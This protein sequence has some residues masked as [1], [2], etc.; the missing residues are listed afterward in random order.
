MS[1]NK[2]GLW[3]RLLSAALAFLMLFELSDS[4][5][6]YVVE[7]MV[8]APTSITFTDADGNTQN[9]DE[10][11]VEAF[12]YGAFAFETSGLAVKEGESG[13][14]KV[15]RL[16][17]TTGRA[18]AYLAYEPVAVQNEA[19]EAIYDY[20]LSADDVTIEV[21][22]PLPRAEYDPVGM[23]P[24]PEV[25]DATVAAVADEEGYILQLSVAADAYQWQIL[26]NDMWDDV[27]D[28]TEAEVPID[29]EY[30][31]GGVYDYRCVYTLDG[32]EY[33]SVSLAG[34][35]Y[36]KPVEEEVPQAPADLDLTAKPTYSALDLAGEEDPYSGWMFELVFAE[37]EWVKEIHVDAL[38]DDLSEAQ[39]AAAFTIWECEGGEVLESANTLLLRV[40]DINE[41]EPSTL[42]FTVSNITV[43]K[44]DGTAEVMIERVGGSQ[45]PVTVEYATADGT[46]VAG[47]DYASAS[48]TL[49]FYA[50]MTSLPVTVELIDD[51]MATDEAVWF[52]IQLS[53]LL[54]DDNCQMTQDV[55]RVEL[56]NSGTGDG[57]NLATQLYDPEA[58][59]VSGSVVESDSAA[60]AS[61]AAVTGTQS[62][63]EEA[64][65]V[66]STLVDPGSDGD[67]SLQSYSPSQKCISFNN[68]TNAWGTTADAAK[69][70]Y[71]QITKN[72][73][74]AS[75]N[76]AGTTVDGV[77]KDYNGAES[78]KIETGVALTSKTDT[79]AKL[80]DS[81]WAAL[82]GTSDIAG[83]MFSGFST[84]ITTRM[85]HDTS[86]LDG[87]SY[88]Y[89]YT[90]PRFNVTQGTTTLVNNPTYI[91]RYGSG[92][93][94]KKWTIRASDSNNFSNPFSGS[95]SKSF[96]FTGAVQ[97]LMNMPY[98]S[99]SDHEHDELNDKSMVWVRELKLTRR[100]FASNAFYTEV[101]TPNDS[102]TAPDKC[103]VLDEESYEVFEPAVEIVSGAGG[104]I[105]ATNQLFV[106]STLKISPARSDLPSG[107]YISDLVIYQSTD[108]GNTWKVFNKFG[109][110][111]Y[112]SASKTYTIKLVGTA[113]NPLNQNDLNAWYKV[114]VCYSRTSTVSVDFSPSVPRL[115]DGK[116]INTGKYGDVF[117]K[118]G[119][120]S[121][122]DF[123]S[124]TGVTGTVTYGYNVF[125]RATGDFKTE[126][127]TTTLQKPTSTTGSGV[128]ID[129]TNQTMKWSFNATNIQW[130]E[131]N[132]SPKDLVLINGGAYPG[133]SRIYL[134]E[135]DFSGGLSVLY[136]H[137][138]FQSAQSAMT[139]AISWMALYWDGNGN[140]KIDG[141][142]N[143][144]ISSF[145]L[146]ESSGDEFCGYIEAGSINEKQ[147]APK[148][149]DKGEYCQYF[150]KVCYTM[151][152]RSLVMPAGASEDERAQ[153]LPAFTTALN[154]DSTAYS[155]LTEELKSYRYIVSGLTKQSENAAETRSSDNHLK[156][157]AEAN[158]RSTLDIPLG[159]DISPA[160]LNSSNTAYVW[161]PVF[162]GNILYPFA[163]PEPITIENS[164]AGPTEVTSDYTMARDEEGI[165]TGYAYTQTGLDRMNG[166][167]SSFT[168]TT[169]FGL[170]TQEQSHTTEEIVDNVTGMKLGGG[171]SG[172]DDDTLYVQDA[173]DYAVR[174]DSVTLSG[175]S[176]TPDGEYLKEMKDNSEAPELDLDMDDA[177]T[178]WPEFNMD[179]GMN[180]GSMELSVLGG[181]T[182]LLDE[183]KIGFA[184]GV[185]FVEGG[186]DYKGF[187]DSN[188]DQWGAFMDFI[189][190]S[191]HG[192]EGYKKANDE[193]KRTHPSPAPSAATG[194]PS[195]SS[196]PSSS[197]PP[198]AASQN[199]VDKSKF[200]SKSYSIS[201]SS[202]VAFLFQYN[203]LD[204][205][206]YFEAMTVS[207]TGGFT[208]RFQGRFTACPILYLYFQF[209][210]SVEV[211]TGL[212]VIR[213]SVEV[214]TPKLNAKTAATADQRV[215][216][217]YM[218]RP[219][220]TGPIIT[221]AQYNS[222][223]ASQK[224]NYSPYD[225]S[226]YYY[227]SA[228]YAT[229]A[230]TSAES[231][232]KAAKDAYLETKE[233][234]LTPDQYNILTDTEKASYKAAP[235]TGGTVNYFYNAKNY[236]SYTD[237]V[238]AYN[239]ATSYSF[240]TSYKAF[241][242]RFSGKLSVEVQTQ[243]NGEWKADDSFYSGL[244]SSDGTGDTQVVL[245]KQDGMKLDKTVRVV[246]RP[247]EYE[248][249][250]VTMDKTTVTYVAEIQDIRNDVYWK[251]VSITP[252]IAVEVGAGVGIELL[253]LE[254]YGRLSAEATFLLGAYNTDY[255][256]YD[257]ITSNDN[258][259][260]PAK[261]D[262]FSAAVCAGLRLVLIFFNFEMD[263]VG[264]RVNYDGEKW[265]HGA[266]FLND[267][268]QS[269]SEDGYL[270][271]T[272]R[273]PQGTEQTFY[274]PEDNLESELGTLA[275]DPSDPSVPFQL[276]GYGSSVDAANLTGNMLL[277]SDYKVISAGDRD[278]IVY[279]ISRSG[280]VAGEDVS[281]LVMSELRQVSDGMGVSKYGLANPNSADTSGNLYLVL[282]NDNT[283]DLDFDVWVEESTSGT[284]TT[285][286]VHT[287][288]VSYDT[289]TTELTEP[290]KPAGDAYGGMTADN[291]KTV[292]APTEP[293]ESSYYTTKTITKDEYDK[294]TDDQKKLCEADGTNYKQ[295]TLASGY[296]TIQAAKDAYTAAQNTYNTAKA[297]YEAWYNYY[298]S[299]DSYN[300]FVQN[301]LKNAAQ[302]TVLKAAEWKY[303]STP[304]ADGSEGATI[305]ND[306]AFS[307]ATKL[308][309]DGNGST[310]T[311]GYVF[312]PASNGDGSAVFFG[313]TL[314]TDPKAY[315]QYVQ[316]LKNSG[317]DQEDYADYLKQTK[318]ST[319][320]VLGTQSNLNLAYQKSD[321]SWAVSSMALNAGQTL[322]NIEFT[323]WNGAYYLAYT[324]Q[325]DTYEGSGS[326]AEHVTA[327]RLFL[328]KV[329]VDPAATDPAKAVTWGDPYLLRTTRDYDLDKGTD[330]IYNSAGTLITAYDSPYFA[331]L[332]FLTAKIDPDM[333]TGTEET[334]STQ[335]VSEHTFLLFEMN[336]A[337]YLILDDSL[338]SITSS[339]KGTIYPFFTGQMFENEDGT[340]SQDASGKQEVTIGSDATGNLFAV[341]VG[342]VPN[343]TN[344][345]LYLSAYDANTNTW[346]DGVMLAMRNMDTYEAS[347]RNGWGDRTTQAAYL[348]F[349]GTNGLT[350]D[351]VKNLYPDYADDILTNL[352]AYPDDLGDKSNLTLSNV[353]AVQGVNGDLLV[354]TQGS[355]S[356]LGVTS[357]TYDGKT[358]YVVVPTYDNGS[359]DTE[360]GMYAISYSKGSQAL[361]EGTISFGQADF[362]MNSELY[363]ALSAVNTGDA[364]FRGSKNQ[365]ITATLSVAGQE[366]AAWTIAENIRSGQTLML[367]G[368]CLPL[369]S[370][371][372][373]GDQFVLT[374]KEDATYAGTAAQAEVTLFTVAE[375][376]DLGVEDLT[377]SVANVSAD[378]TTTTL[379][380]DFVAANRGSAQ[381]EDV[382]AQFTYAD[383]KDSNDETT[384]AVL[385]LTNSNL[386]IDQAQQLETLDASSNTDLANG[387]LKIYNATDGNND[388]EAGY[389]RRVHGTI[390]VPS[391]VFAMGEAGYLEL[392][393]ELFSK[394]DTITGSNVGVLTAIHD[395]YC[396]S[397][398][399]QTATIQAFTT[400]TVAPSLVIPMGTTTL[401][402][403]SAISA[404]G[405]KPAL[406]AIEI[407][408]TSDGSNLG[409]L[410]F[411][412]SS[413]SNGTV[414]GVLSITPSKPGTGVIHLYDANT[415]SFIA[416][417]FIVTDATDGIDIYSDNGLFTFYNTDDTPYNSGA[418]IGSQDWQFSIVDKWGSEE[419]EEM[420]LRRNLSIGDEGAYFTFY[421]VAESID[422]Y[423][424]G[425]AVVSSTDYPGFVDKNITGVGG[426]SPVTIPLG[427]NP[428]NNRYTITIRVT[429][430]K[431]WFDRMRESYS[432]GVVPTPDYD[433]NNPFLIWSRSFP[434]K[435]SVASGSIPL[436]FYAL[437]N[438]G[439]DYVSINGVR[440]N[441]TSKEVT[442]LDDGN[443]DSLLWRY[444]FGN[445]SANGNYKI[446]VA[447]ISGNLYSTE[448]EVDWFQA[449]ASDPNNTVNVP[450]Y[451]A[452]FY[453]D[454]AEWDGSFIGKDEINHLNITFTEQSGN[455]KTSNNTHMVYSFDGSG[456]TELNATA[457]N[458]A[459]FQIGANGIY[460]TKTLNADGTF[461]TQFLY[462]GQVDGSLPQ[463]ELI[464]N[465]LTSSLEWKAYKEG[466]TSSEITKVTINGY[467][468]N[469]Q[470][471]RNLFG[472]L[473]V[474]CNGTY[475]IVADDASGNQ[476]E[477]TYHMTEK[478]LDLDTCTIV[479]TGAWNQD[480]NNGIVD[481]DLSDATGG[482]FH[483]GDSDKANNIYSARFETALVPADYDLAG[484]ADDAE[485]T[486]TELSKQNQFKHTYTDRTPGDYLLVVQ[487]QVD[488]TN[489]VTIPVTVA[490]DAITMETAT[491]DASTSFT[492]DGQVLVLA[493]KGNTPAFEFAIARVN[494][495]EGT[496][497]TIEEF[498]ALDTAES[499][500]DD[501]VWTVAT[502]QALNPWAK[503]FE[504]VRAGQYLVA[505]RGAYGATEEQIAALVA[506]GQPLDE[507]KQALTEAQEAYYAAQDDRYATEEQ[508]AALKAA[509]EAAQAQVAEK[510]AAYDSA[511]KPIQEASAANYP[512]ET[513]PYWAGAIVAVVEVKGGSPSSTGSSSNLT[514]IGSDDKDT[515]VYHLHTLDKELTDPDNQKIVQSNQNKNV[516]LTGGGLTVFIPK[517]TLEEGFDVNRLIVQPGQ[518]ESGMVIRYTDV[519]GNPS[520]LPWCLVEEDSV[521]YIA[522][523]MGDYDLVMGSADFQD[524]AGLWGESYI[525]F[526]ARRELFAGTGEGLFSPDMPM[527]RAMFVTV[528]WRMAGSPEGEGDLTFTDLK[529]DWYREAVRWAVANGITSGY[530]DQLFG[531]ED[532]V[533]REQ[534][535]VFLCR[536]LEYLGWTLDRE[537][538]DTDFADGKTISAWALESVE[539]CA[540]T[541]LVQGVG[542]NRFAP[543]LS[544]SRMEV[545]TL[546]TQFVTKLVEKY[547]D[548]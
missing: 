353:Q 207:L 268:V 460:Q 209:S 391:K 404:R 373:N 395:E 375:V 389:G 303:T 463:V 169:T 535:C 109:N 318:K 4:A 174:P 539:F 509:V 346:G 53:E 457:D 297:S 270:G 423:F 281:Q 88:K 151:T 260:E 130:I 335:A 436:S 192:D 33:C 532:P 257:D 72:A 46:A 443:E 14:I 486:W 185:P 461:S 27:L 401:I 277:G 36:E 73:G 413:A 183:N 142:Y 514:G 280:S 215:E 308:G 390:Q 324:T 400:Y 56:T 453:L 542:G 330:G 334:F 347:I 350:E 18:T 12:P 29:A 291:Y 530:S 484:L 212:G 435:A 97:M 137:E 136:Y 531:P 222:L 313:S 337:T 490:D 411:R 119:N 131:L 546:L 81:G 526:A 25:G 76:G 241:N 360:L 449:N 516:V 366:I 34:E 145:V 434:A 140:G 90:M 15:Y 306:A 493:D 83:Q 402:P 487:D 68:P 155:Q 95:Y 275:Y 126:T 317:M 283:G 465:D 438:N 290:T 310:D 263:V 138:D 406:G 1:G 414:S 475:V 32:V 314:A 82:G 202:S 227:N 123:S 237:A 117:N 211:T 529:A 89:S 512:D 451:D 159:G 523:G 204:N 320:D 393:I 431:A 522:V 188:K 262:S 536:F 351:E 525:D 356:E 168:G 167:L 87:F 513:S 462:M 226:G 521:Q 264:Y 110:G 3:R 164:V 247:M 96:T 439:L 501:I 191:D 197:T 545:S 244:I 293:A 304:A 296:T 537:T 41:P 430:E 69:A 107:Y 163:A 312:A 382:Y 132:L 442:V 298:A 477:Y 24:S 408:D 288:W 485:L 171:A 446:T 412:E 206:Y 468:V 66:Y 499:S 21:E 71:W 28:A 387:I 195:T 92:P 125:D 299:L 245:K 354:V 26:N 327:N 300:A 102:N 181:A 469:T 547:C 221:T 322:S 396:S 286:T 180:L 122:H 216:L 329:T 196:P 319:L 345:A 139:T 374:L 424:K 448:L 278:F 307:G 348:G 364:A 9:V 252:A 269:A 455:Q 450:L 287:A 201:L 70:N 495:Y 67:L 187:L 497:P 544:A 242:V 500:E 496:E 369:I 51:G 194:T 331:N 85:G 144:K 54:G 198:S 232:K 388:L 127:A 176:T 534:M 505:V 42:G 13:V 418:S 217:T 339:G 23:P 405:T 75:L 472:D 384:Y 533:S 410:N 61:G 508:L 248:E 124:G 160:Q 392:K 49:M 333:L 111:S 45:R 116:T 471:G 321:G 538:D 358:E 2:F 113:S 259:Y 378:G 47:K 104:A 58:V 220:A 517:G 409:V 349:G 210:F 403:V 419:Y 63:M 250:E 184:I 456:F 340:Q 57:S 267:W 426:N 447:D 158:A 452:G 273:V 370:D 377:V 114:R 200:R 157:G 251:G 64:E 433:G 494:E 65:P 60:N 101:A 77:G 162:R 292:S 491:L 444:D 276:S 153:I 261:V 279:T 233:Y 179:M 315:D 234:F 161:S 31:D 295:Y 289:A 177:D 78:V 343:T 519:D 274:T 383:G 341:Y 22:N 84:S 79:E 218:T 52:E 421:T 429:S 170:V 548:K 178:E 483:E 219:S 271:V 99:Y 238:K 236:Q 376:P 44:A 205:D 143:T 112:D 386:T 510:Q 284:T 256:P 133:D 476:I 480:R 372:K 355:L 357:Y 265:T 246:L 253:K 7:G 473:P 55:V 243:Q 482:T 498:L 94:D 420:P 213:D 524:I 16:G 120:E 121:D 417:S 149:N 105:K 203:P 282:D 235:V 415:K 437:D 190:K 173:S 399:S 309:G 154:P 62:A 342:S 540:G 458:P 338:E 106:G 481:V 223:Q 478:K 272:I 518:A 285:Y 230:Q 511:A 459:K 214:D 379:N 80:S 363:V 502:N 165:I 440:Y 359:M 428:D 19:G 316:F 311:V 255:D 240:E 464:Y 150:I 229:N 186:S 520:I 492:N 258:K 368:T 249:E 17:G 147:F 488:K 146:D 172:A 193:Y 323:Q 5:L 362:S 254:F 344:N 445:I 20:A 441:A 40:E 8:N 135:S 152:P 148:K 37:G 507:A 103:T 328:R 527:S 528:L 100:T 224:S 325:Q 301:R 365:P 74:S 266:Y 385:P 541:G 503:T 39:E 302:N 515:V 166:Y 115:D 454:S 129:N 479:P 189:R 208:F 367:A 134:Q 108:K 50:G 489:M 352:K 141:Y 326:N 506:A 398:N 43:D 228:L 305:V 38:T 156:Y 407:D 543:Q 380:V 35:T 422:L 86:Y 182:I 432:S 118:Y 397:N 91:N 175:Y 470:S 199:P 11:W 425:T 59:D 416:V 466:S 93:L 427:S 30:I 98:Q 10:S 504:G 394:S 467:Q 225:V 361:G 231:A 6:A 381:A 371:L 336:G 48:G 474:T 332:S 128:V 294:L 239:S